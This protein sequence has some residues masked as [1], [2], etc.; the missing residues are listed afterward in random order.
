MIEILWDTVRMFGAAALVLLLHCETDGG[1]RSLPEDILT[2]S[3]GD[4]LRE[5]RSIEDLGRLYRRFMI[6]KE[7]ACGQQEY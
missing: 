3:V 7:N 1:D 6:T 5:S 2:M 4:Y